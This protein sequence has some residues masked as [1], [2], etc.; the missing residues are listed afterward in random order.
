MLNEWRNVKKVAWQQW[1]RNQNW[2]ILQ[3]S[4]T[5]TTMINENMSQRW[6]DDNSMVKIEKLNKRQ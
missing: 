5:V 2:A 4:K 6:H 1:E 3:N